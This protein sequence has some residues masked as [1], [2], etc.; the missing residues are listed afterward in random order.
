MLSEYLEE[1][2][3]YLERFKNIDINF[4]DVLKM[5]KKFIIWR[6]KQIFGDSSTIFTN[7]SSEITIFDKIFQM[8]DYDIDGEVEKRLPKDESRFMIGVR[9]EKEIEIKKEIITNLL[10][11]LLII[12]LSHTPYFNAFVRKYAEIKKN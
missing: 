9:R 8:I 11:F 5:S 3:E 2:K 6:L 7:I 4:S 10:D 12:L 1:F